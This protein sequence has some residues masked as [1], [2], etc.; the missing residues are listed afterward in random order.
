MKIVHVLISKGRVDVAAETLTGNTPLHDACEEPNPVIVKTLLEAGAKTVV[1]LKNGEGNTP[2]HIA[3]N[4][5]RKGDPRL[6]KYILKTVP[7]FFFS[8]S[9]SF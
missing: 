6:T 3:V 2:L 9:F 4:A 7:I 5:L 1:N 8:F